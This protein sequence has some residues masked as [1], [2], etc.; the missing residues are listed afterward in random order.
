MA[1]DD[2][3]NYLARLEG[4]LRDLRIAI[5]LCTRLPVAPSSA[6]GEGDLARA[7]WAFPI[8]GALIGLIGAAVYWIADRLHLPPL[9]ASVLALA[10]TIFLS[11]AMHEDGLADAADGL[12]GGR[13]REKKLEI[14][15]DSRIGTFGACALG[16]SL[17]LRWSA[18][19]TLNDTRSVAIA[20]IV[21]HAA[22]RAV[23]PAFMSLVPPARSEGLSSSAG[24]PQPVSAAI[25]LGLGI[26]ALAIGFGLKAMLTGAVALAAIGLLLARLAQRQI[27]GQTGDVLGALEQAAEATLL[28]LATTLL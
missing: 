8:A 12:G 15:R 26:A 18:L 11:G 1:T 13:T 28:L 23:L 25:A 27:G 24:Q 19:A 3:V 4:L 21:A 20:L 5:S 14:M 16:L 7:S 9:A 17:L 10:A 22:A 6:I 2:R